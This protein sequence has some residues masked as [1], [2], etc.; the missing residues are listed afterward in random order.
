[1]T[2][3][4]GAASLI[5]VRLL[6]PN[7][8]P[9]L[10]TAYLEKRADLVRFFQ[11]RLRSIEAAEDL[12]QDIFVR[13]S[14]LDDSQIDNPVAYLYRLGW[15]MMLD[16]LRQQRRTLAREEDWSGTQHTLVAHEAV[17]ETP[18]AEEAVAAR[19]RLQRI[20]EA[21]GALPPKTQRVFRMHKFDGLSHAEVAAALGVSRSAVEKHVSAALRHLL[22]QRL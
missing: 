6:L 19:Q 12:V 11:L 18:S 15:N 4:R 5:L 7:A 3:G 2:A 9:P 8:V 1:M 17:A 21:L 10:R 13:V 16:K 22:K 14:S 20:V